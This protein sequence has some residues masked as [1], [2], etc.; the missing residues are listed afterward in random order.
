MQITVVLTDREA[1]VLREACRR[2]Q[3]G[4]AQHLLRHLR[5]PPDRRDD[6]P[7]VL[8]EAMSKLRNVLDSPRSR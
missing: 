2:F 5:S 1:A 3:F 4:D 8:C 7:D 6:R